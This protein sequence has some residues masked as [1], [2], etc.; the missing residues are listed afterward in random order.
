MLSS[1][2]LAIKTFFTTSKLGVL[3]TI[4]LSKAASTVVK[5]IMNKENQQK[6][7]DFVKEL[8]DNTEM[9]NAQ[10]AKV[11][12]KK[13]AEWAANEGKKMAE[14]V[15]NCL[16]ELAVNALKA[17]IESKENKEKEA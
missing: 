17:E 13:M 7:Y 3:I 12:N 1:I 2:W 11:F 15:I 10:K 8:N 5:D 9:T 16:R 4:I 14:S 6:A